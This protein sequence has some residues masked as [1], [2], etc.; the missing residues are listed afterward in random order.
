MNPE[1]NTAKNT[2]TNAAENAKK[3]MWKNP[4]A[5]S[6]A[7]IAIVLL[8]LGGF[9]FWQRGYGTVS[10]E[11][12]LL[13]APVVNLSANAP[14]IL[15]AL[16]VKEGDTIAANVPVASV[17]TN[18][19]S[20]KQDGIVVGVANN[21]GAYFNPGSSIVSMIHPSDFRVVGQI[22]ENKGL[23]DIKAGQRA[24]FTVD[25][26]PGKTYVGFVES[27]G[28]TASNTGVVFSIS[29]KRPTQKFDVKVKF[30]VSQY[31]ELKNGMSAKITVYTK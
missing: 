23:E 2:E 7:G 15:N 21:L 29:D 20:S 6:V 14:G 13:V 27:V 3:S 16:Y 11:N 24:S 25:A 4:I 9:L 18:I 8:A 22:E 5:Q 10:I 12:S 1:N 30:D 26:F 19:V 17:G 28:E 31:P